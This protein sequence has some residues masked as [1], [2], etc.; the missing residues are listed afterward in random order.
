MA[1]GEAIMESKFHPL[2]ENVKNK[3][4]LRPCSLSGKGKV[5]VIV[6][7]LSLPCITMVLTEARNQ[8]NPTNISLRCRS[9]AEDRETPK[10]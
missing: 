6:T 8:Y 7:A 4:C 2:A 10:A 9:L 3:Q 1:V 5:L